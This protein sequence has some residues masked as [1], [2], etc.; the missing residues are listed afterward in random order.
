MLIMF[1]TML[2]NVAWESRVLAWLDGLL[3]ATLLVGAMYVGWPHRPWL[4]NPKWLGQQLRNAAVGVCFLGMIVLGARLFL[5]ANPSIFLLFVGQSAL[6]CAWQL[7]V[8]QRKNVEAPPMLRN[9]YGP[10]EDRPS[11][12]SG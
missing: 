2:A 3:A 1:V 12:T 8:Y 9:A 6:A 10:I 11:L 7:R 4:S 5:P